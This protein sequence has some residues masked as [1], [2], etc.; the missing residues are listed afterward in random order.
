[1]QSITKFFS[2]KKN[3]DD[4]DFS[5]SKNTG[6][7]KKNSKDSL[8]KIVDNEVENIT[9]LLFETLNGDLDHN[10]EKEQADEIAQTSAIKV[11][12]SKIPE[13][14]ENSGKPTSSCIE[15]NHSKVTAVEILED[16]SP[17]PNRTR[18]FS[19]NIK[20]PSRTPQKVTCL[21]SRSKKDAMDTSF[22]EALSITVN[23]SW[24]NPIEDSDI[25]STHPKKRL[26]KGS[27]A[28][29]S[30]SSPTV[31]KSHSLKLV[32]RKLTIPCL[33]LPSAFANPLKNKEFYNLRHSISNSRQKNYV[34]M[35]RACNKQNQTVYF[36][37]EKILTHKMGSQSEKQYKFL[38]KWSDFSEK[39]TSWEPEEHF[40][41]SPH[42]LLHYITNLLLTVDKNSAICEDLK[43]IKTRL[44]KRTQKISAIKSQVHLWQLNAELS[45]QA[46]KVQYRRLLKQYANKVQEEL[47]PSFPTVEIL[48]TVD[49]NL[50][51]LNFTFVR[52]RFAGKG[53]HISDDT[54]IGCVCSGEYGVKDCCL[55]PHVECCPHLG[56]A[57]LPYNNK[58]KLLLKQGFPIYECNARC[59]CG[60]DCGNRIVQ[61]GTQVKT[62]IYKTPD[63]GWGLKTLQ[64]IPKGTFVVEYVGEVITFDEA[65][66]RGKEYDAQGLT[67][68]F[69]LDYQ[70]TEG[71]EVDEGMFTIDAAF[72]G[73]TSHF[74]NHSCD[75]NLAVFS[76]WISNLDLRLPHICL[77]AV[78]SIAAGEELTFNYQIDRIV[79]EDNRA[80]QRLSVECRCG[81]KKCV[82]Y[83]HG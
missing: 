15:Q 21:L 56:G 3:E 69:D 55:S 77:F 41:C 82:R 12:D 2:P 6:K 64:N 32:A 37:I 16:K 35:K 25:E 4:S 7:I 73:N 34:V 78:K 30:P 47:G 42:L 66:Q 61:R 74:I 18:R 1:M 22:D 63:K 14:E 31:A 83:L 23:N 60:P 62:A 36:E 5:L 49:F 70:T 53:V 40:N 9:G 81:T 76:C 59:S 38:V 13:T 68:L 45:S 67:Y 29:E 26:R 28:S 8:L 39:Y 11:T 50:P 24:A 10:E 52:D 51:P 65:E 19:F 44:K 71:T 33:Q 48:N 72:Y 17:T 75:P 79:E 54:L 43:A 46:L 20:S 27:S 80:A 58:G 57:A